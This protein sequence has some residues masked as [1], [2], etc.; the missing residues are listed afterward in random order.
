MKAERGVAL[1]EFALALPMLLIVMLLIIEFGRAYYQYDML[2][3][4]VREAVRYLSVRSPGVDVDKAKNIV[5]YG[6]PAGTGTPLLPGLT[7]ANVPDPT[8]STS[9]SY[10]TLNTVTVTVTGYTFMPLVKGVSWITFDDI[11]FGTIQ[12]TM[13]SPT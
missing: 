6:N 3:K 2:T 9:G 11:A 1:T 12:A 8:W 5:V 4:S 7:L 13:R 10:P